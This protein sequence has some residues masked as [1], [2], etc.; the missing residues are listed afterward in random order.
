M[1]KYRP[2]Y[3]VFIFLFFLIS[4]FMAISGEKAVSKDAG[5]YDE[6]V[7]L[8]REWR[9]FQKPRVVNG[10]PD[11]SAAAMKEQRDKLA[12]FQKRL[13]AID[14]TRWPVA[15]QVDYHLVRA[16]MNGLEFDHRVLRPWSRMPNFYV[17]VTASEHDVPLREGPEI[18]DPLNLWK[19]ELPLGEKEVLEY[20][21]KLRAVPAILAQGKKNLVEET[22]DLWTL[23]IPEIRG[24]SRTLDYLARQLAKY[25]PDIAPE[26]K[27]AKSAVDDFLFWVEEKEKTMKPAPCG[28]GVENFDWYMKNVHLVPY[29]WKEQVAVL[30]REWERSTASLKLEEHR[31]RHL[32]ELVPLATEEEARRRYNEAV[33]EFMRFLREESV[34]TVPDYLHLDYFRGRF[35]PPDAQR[36]FFAKVE[37]LD[38]MPMKC[39]SMHWLDKQLMANDPHPSPIRRVPLLYNIW[40]SRAEGLATAMEELMMQ[41]G[42]LDERPRAKELV[43]ILVAMRCARA[44]GDLKMHSNKWNL[45]Q[46]RQYAVER[47]PYGWLLRDGETIWTDLRIYLQQPGYG[48][49]YVVGKVQIDKLMA[50]RSG[51]M[52]AG[53]KLQKFMDE[54]LGCGMIPVSLSRWEM[55]GLED[56]IKK[57]W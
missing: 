46:A 22:K 25:H 8:F 45:E 12:A 32:P 40:D 9:E 53:F 28:I 6:L 42:L 44:M 23:G 54:F 51:Q 7:A 56:E 16:E 37:S 13:A 39:H 1:N 55:T 29:T 57:L 14:C 21:E 4:G 48:T 41:A 33:D 26:A 30:E 5:S 3:L 2:L 43:Y 35:A 50:D 47:T 19:H 38:S 27:R 10:V 24:E 18:F 17:S 36:D 20:R 34:F 11:Y 49:S 52:G 31:N 15:Q